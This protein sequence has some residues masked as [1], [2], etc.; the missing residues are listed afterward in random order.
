MN[1]KICRRDPCSCNQWTLRTQAKLSCQKQN[2]KD[3]L[4]LSYHPPTEWPSRSRTLLRSGDASSSKMLWTGEN[5]CWPLLLW[6]RIF[7]VHT[8]IGWVW[9]LVNGTYHSNVLFSVNGTYSLYSTSQELVSLCIQ[10]QGGRSRL[11]AC[12]NPGILI[13]HT[14]GPEVVMVLMLIVCGFECAWRVR[15]APGSI[16]HL[17]YSWL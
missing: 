6:F 9:W 13:V 11:G 7:K 5:T 1:C 16:C 15:G 17:Q 2:L 3:A 10:P 14:S 8:M 4:A 12:L